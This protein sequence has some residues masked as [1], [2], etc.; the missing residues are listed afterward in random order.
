MPTL[1]SNN[2]QIPHSPTTPTICAEGHLVTG[3]GFMPDHEVNVRITRAE[4][5]VDDYLAYVTDG[6]GCF[7]CDLPNNITGTLYMAATDHRPH[8]NGDGGLLWSNTVVITHT[9]R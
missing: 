5:D 9:D 1:V 7:R 4:D 3:S 8:P 6:D 2:P